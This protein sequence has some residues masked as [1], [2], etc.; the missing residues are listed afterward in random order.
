MSQLIDQVFAALAHAT[1]IRPP[2][3]G[4]PHFAEALRR[5][6]FT[7]NYWTLPS[8]QS[9]VVTNAGAVSIQGPVSATSPVDIPSFDRDALIAAIRADQAGTTTF[10]EFLTGAWQ[11]GVVRYT[12]D[13]AART[14]AYFGVHGEEYVEA[15]PPVEIGP[16]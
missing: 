8:G 15:Y 6:G 5:A 11:A 9:I 2:V 14:V 10:P 1:A 16:A 13:F 4:F 3:G 7:H 12:V